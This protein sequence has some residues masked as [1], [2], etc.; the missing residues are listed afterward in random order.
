ME[1]VSFKE[2]MANL[3]KETFKENVS[4]TAIHCNHFGII[5]VKII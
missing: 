3:K 1:K 4:N 5:F 2:K